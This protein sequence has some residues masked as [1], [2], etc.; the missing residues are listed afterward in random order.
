MWI[1]DR[2]E[3]DFAIIECG[4]FTFN[5]PKEALPERVCEGDVITVDIDRV[6]TAGRQANASSLMNK[7]F[8]EKR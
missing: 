7:L 4:D 8:G 1:V 5:V 2:F 6:K 3:G